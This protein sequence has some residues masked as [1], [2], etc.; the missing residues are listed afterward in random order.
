M[1]RQAQVYSQRALVTR[2]CRRIPLSPNTHSHTLAPG[3]LVWRL[4]HH[5][6]TA[7]PISTTTPTAPPMIGRGD[8]PPP[9]SLLSP[10][11][12]GT[13]SEET[14]VVEA[15]TST[16]ACGSPVCERA[17]ENGNQRSRVSF[18]SDCNQHLYSKAR[19]SGRRQIWVQAH[20]GTQTAQRYLA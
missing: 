3:L 18:V 17:K 8:I 7:I 20:K 6:A 2:V 14:A 10:L 13:A 19:N 15:L 4:H 9:P 16:S 11:T 1:H 5:H 12:V